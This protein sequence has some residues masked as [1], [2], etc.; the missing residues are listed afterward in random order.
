MHAGPG[1]Q[2]SSHPATRVWNSVSRMRTL[3]LSWNLRTRARREAPADGAGE[4]PCGAR[5]G[6]GPRGL[7]RGDAGIA[8]VRVDLDTGELRRV[9]DADVERAEPVVAE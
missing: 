3:E 4:V 9:H 8:A 5:G 7:A 2:G 1:W 6:S